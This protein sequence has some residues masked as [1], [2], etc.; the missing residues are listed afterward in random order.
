MSLLQ[1]PEELWCSIGDLVDVPDLLT[2]VR[3]SAAPLWGRVLQHRQRALRRQLTEGTW[4]WLTPRHNANQR[5]GRMVR[6]MLIQDGFVVARSYLSFIQFSPNVQ[7]IHLEDI[8]SCRIKWVGHGVDD[9]G[10]MRCGCCIER[11]L[12]TDDDEDETDEETDDET[13]ET[14]EMD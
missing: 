11:E 6:V 9:W 1:I 8:D 2:L 3:T 4:C 12:C 10:R 13:D 5:H 7:S 14:D